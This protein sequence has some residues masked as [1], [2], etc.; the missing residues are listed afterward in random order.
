MHAAPPRRFA[1]ALLGL[2]ASVALLRPAAADVPLFPID[3][4]TPGMKGVAVTVLQGTR[5]DSLPVEV[6]GV[7]PGYSPGSHVVLVRG[8]G[9]LAELGIAQGMSGSPV[10]IDGRLVGALAFA[11]SGA[12][13][14]IGGVTPFGEMVQDLTPYFAGAPAPGATGTHAAGGGLRPDLPAFPEWRDRCAKGEFALRRP[15]AMA[16]GGGAAAGLV[17]IGLP[18]ALEGPGG[19]PASLL[20]SVLRRAGLTPV[21]GGGSGEGSGPGMKGIAGLGPGP[22][23]APVAGGS[24]APGPALRLS[25]GDAAAVTLV[26]GDMTA[27]AIGTVTWVDGDRVYAFGHPFLFSGATW[28]PFARAR[29]AAVIPTLD[30]SFK[31]GTP[32][33]EIGVLVGDKRTGVAARLGGRAERVSLDITIEDAGQGGGTESHHYS[34]AKHEFLTPVLMAGAAASALTSERFALGLATLRAEIAIELEDGRTLARR[35]IF[36][37][38]NPGLTAAGEALAPAT[39]LIDNAFASLP[40]R[41]VRLKLALEPTIRAEQIEGIRALKLEV[42]PGET[43][44]L[45]IRLREFRGATRARR[46]DLEIPAGVAA[47]DL[48]VLAGSPTAFYEWD[49]DR[50]PDKY[51]PRSL[52]DLVRLIETYPSEESLIVRLYGPSRGVVHRGHELPSLPRS[53][54]HALSTGSTGGETTVVSG[55]ILSETVVMTGSV[56]LGGTYV[57]VRVAP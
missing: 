49:Q 36:R 21:P 28:L 6:V 12:R 10:F 5:P 35:D 50:A 15:P 55:A 11:F 51:R 7:Y 37:T 26:S 46:V 34:I 2:I 42:R 24:E 33:E 53:K 17:P 8:Q 41:A 3:Q 32:T 23:S 56:V 1:R 16:P 19:G 48:L 4:L 18:V 40:V 52:D 22:A 45:E 57:R 54:W 9:R 25:P 30:V 13:E 14:A 27:A 38:I 43:L 44:P 20:E 31:V 29:I 47:Q 39:Y